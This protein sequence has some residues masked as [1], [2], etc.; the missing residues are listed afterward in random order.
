[1]LAV[2]YGMGAE[3]LALRIGQPVISARELLRLHR[4]TYRV[5]WQWSDAAVDYAMLHGKLWTVFGWTVHTGTNPNPRFLRNF[6]MQA[7][8]AEMLRLACCMLASARC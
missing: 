4:D 8:G 1:M 3:S 5:F 6:L 7:N 2:Q